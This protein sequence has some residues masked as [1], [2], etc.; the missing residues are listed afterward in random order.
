MRAFLMPSPS[1][2]DFQ[3]RVLEGSRFK[4]LLWPSHSHNPLRSQ[5]VHQALFAVTLFS[6]FD[7]A[8]LQA[9]PQSSS[10]KGIH[11]PMLGWFHLFLCCTEPFQLCKTNL[12]G[13]EGKK[14]IK[15]CLCILLW[16]NSLLLFIMNLVLSR[17]CWGRGACF[18]CADSANWY[19]EGIV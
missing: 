2:A 14:S 6:S 11:L 12:G 5:S 9:N 7:E 4:I 15:L 10:V 17:A 3:L 1:C 8:C 19:F 16:G 13:D 18:V